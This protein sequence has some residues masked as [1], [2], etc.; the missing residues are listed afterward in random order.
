M[1]TSDRPALGNRTMAAIQQ[2]PDADRQSVTDLLLQVRQGTPEAMD[3]LFSLVYAQLRRMAH[4]QLQGERPGHTLGTTGLVHEAYLKLVDQSR[5]DWQDRGHFF[6]MAARAMRQ[7]LVD[8]A[9]RYRT[10]RRGGGL[11]RVELTDEPAIEEQAELV[12]DVHE[13]LGRLAG[14]NERLSRVVECRYFAGL[15][16]EETAAALG[17]TART[18]ERDWVKAKGW[19][20]QELRG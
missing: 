3:R 8:Y 6:A 1:A 2:S 4:R 14:V 20:Y 7:V 19:L 12:L 13:A 9:R 15:T 5:I 11:K 18:V 16:E 10:Q 17:V